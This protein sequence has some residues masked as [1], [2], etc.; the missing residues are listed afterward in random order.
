VVEREVKY[1]LAKTGFNLQ[2]KKGVSN[3]LGI[4]LLDLSKSKVIIR[5]DKKTGEIVSIERQGQAVP[6]TPLT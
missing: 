6:N 5:R 2:K 1:H 4:V 3:F